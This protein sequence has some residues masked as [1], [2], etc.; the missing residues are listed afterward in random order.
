MFDCYNGEPCYRVVRAAGAK[1]YT[2]AR[3]KH[4]T[5]ICSFVHFTPCP[6]GKHN[7]KLVD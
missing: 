2:I 3:E 5:H 1:R 7:I 4:V 6:G